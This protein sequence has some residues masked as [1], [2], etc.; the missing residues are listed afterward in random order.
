MPGATQSTFSISCRGSKRGWLQVLSRGLTVSPF[1]MLNISICS[2]DFRVGLSDVPWF[3]Q[4]GTAAGCIQG[5]GLA[6][7]TRLYEITPTPTF[8]WLFT[9]RMTLAGSIADLAE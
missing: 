7:G 9:R 6:A 8:A 2:F 4:T 1:V 5:L 3:C